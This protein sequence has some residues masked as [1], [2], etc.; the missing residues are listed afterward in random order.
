M[1]RWNARKYAVRHAR[2]VGLTALQLQQDCDRTLVRSISK[3]KRTEAENMVRRRKRAKYAKE[4]SDATIEVGIL[5]VCAEMT[6]LAS[7]QGIATHCSVVC[8]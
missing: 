1:C 2:R 8:G 5:R 4:F 7:C 3:P 6:V